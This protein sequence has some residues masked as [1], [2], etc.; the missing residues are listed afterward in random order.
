VKTNPNSKAQ[1]VIFEYEKLILA[2]D[3]VTYTRLLNEAIDGGADDDKVTVPA[4]RSS[5]CLYYAIE[6]LPPI[7]DPILILNGENDVSLADEDYYKINNVCF[8][9]QVSKIE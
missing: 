7:K 4:P 5:V 6:G 8:P 2:T 3:P 9:S 1:D